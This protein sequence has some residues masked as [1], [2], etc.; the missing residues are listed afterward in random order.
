MITFTT[1]K[2]KSGTSPIFNIIYIYYSLI[3][4]SKTNILIF[5]N[6]TAEAIKFIQPPA[7]TLTRYI[8]KKEFLRTKMKKQQSCNYKSIYSN[9]TKKNLY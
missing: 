2:N 6:T 7:T 4:Q 1:I 8:Q 5:N 3:K 9:E